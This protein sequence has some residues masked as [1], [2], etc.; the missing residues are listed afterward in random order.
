LVGLGGDRSSAFQGDRLFPIEY[1]RDANIIAAKKR[2]PKKRRLEPFARD[3]LCA[4]FIAFCFPSFRFLRAIVSTSCLTEPKAAIFSPTCGSA[5]D[6][7][8]LLDGLTWPKTG[9]ASIV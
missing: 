6:A 7:R 4:D 1:G 3:R 5:H 9:Y 2:N 8:G